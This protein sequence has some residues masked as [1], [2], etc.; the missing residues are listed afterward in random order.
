MTDQIDRYLDGAQDGTLT[1]EERASTEKLR[2]AVNETR[3]FIT[4]QREPDLT[5]RV[6]Q[7][8]V[9]DGLHPATE[10]RWDRFRRAAATLWTARDVSFRFR[11]AYGLV[12]AA[13]LVLLTVFLPSRQ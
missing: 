10:T 3:A 7:Q 4:A 1:P 6:M 5:G 13:A 9:Q 8:I 2:Q 12:A 11:P